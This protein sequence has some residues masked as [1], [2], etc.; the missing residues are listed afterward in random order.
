MG[1]LG[2]VVVYS[3]G[4]RAWLREG[5]D[6]YV[7]LELGEPQPTGIRSI[8]ATDR[9]FVAAANDE[10]IEYDAVEGAC[11][12]RHTGVGELVITMRA[13]PEGRVEILSGAYASFALTGTAHFQL[14]PESSADEACD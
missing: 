2:G 5:V 10:L 8:V 14:V 6:R 7:A 13:G 1:A 4:G 12:S 3:S 9:G 11:A